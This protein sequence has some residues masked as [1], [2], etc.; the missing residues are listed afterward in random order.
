MDI[1]LEMWIWI[2]IWYKLLTTISQDESTDANRC[3]SN[4]GKRGES[5][6]EQWTNKLNKKN[7]K[8]VVRYVRRGDSLYVP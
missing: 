1:V 7:D 3:T 2:G 4:G 5:R 6:A 8:H